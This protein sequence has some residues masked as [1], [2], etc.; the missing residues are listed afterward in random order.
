MANSKL[1]QLIEALGKATDEGRVQWETTAN[2]N[3]FRTLLQAGFVEIGT[4]LQWDD[5]LGDYGPPSYFVASLYDASGR[6]ADRIDAPQPMLERIHT[7]ARRQ[8]LQADQLVEDMLHQLAKP[9]K[10]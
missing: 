8:A 4:E 3:A 7:I 6:L 10:K 9:A 1:L 5:E 2:E